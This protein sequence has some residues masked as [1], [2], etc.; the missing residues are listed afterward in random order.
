MTGQRE[1]LGK[2]EQGG[3]LAASASH[4]TGS[5]RLKICSE[6]T[7]LGSWIQAFGDNL[8]NIV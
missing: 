7:E 8:L 3:R 1:R 5:L 2:S 6:A 4:A